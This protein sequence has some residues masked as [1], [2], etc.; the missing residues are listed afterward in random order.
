MNSSNTPG[1]M[2]SKFM[3][4]DIG[5]K[6]FLDRYALKDVGLK[7]L[8]V[9]DLVVAADVEE[10]NT[11][12]LAYVEA[13]NGDQVV[14]RLEDG[15]KHL[16]T[17]DQ[18][19]KPIEHTPAEMH[20]RVSKA[21]V[22]NE[23]GTGRY[24]QQRFEYV[25]KAWKFIPAGR[26]LSAAGSSS[27]LTYYNCYVIKSPKD[28]RQGI[29]ATLSEM[30][31][32]MSR[33]GGVG[34]NISSLRYNSAVIRKV[35]GKSSGS[36]SWAE[37]YSNTTGLISQGGSRRGALLLMLDCWH[38][39]V[40]E[41]I[42]AKEDSD[43]LT[44]ANVTV[45]VY[46]EFMIA[47]KK[48]LDWDLVF[49]DTSYKD[50]DEIW[51]G[52]LTR[53]KEQGLPIKVIK[54]IKAR[55]LWD[56]ISNH[57]WS[58]AEPGLW[59]KDRANKYSNSWY[60]SN[61]ICVNPCGE[62]SLSGDNVCDLGSIN[63]PLFFIP[64]TENS[65]ADIDWEAL[66]FVIWSGVRFLDNVIDANTYFLKQ[67]E[68]Q[69][70]S[71]RRIGLGTMG[72]G[73]LLIRMKL[74]YGSKEAVLF[75]YKLYSFIAHQAYEA[76]V[77]LARER[78]PFLRFDK[79]LFL[80]SKFVQQLDIALQAKIA[81]YGI[82][83]VTI[84]SQAPTGSIATMYGTSTG[85][86]PFYAFEF[87][88]K[89]RL[90]THTIRAGV[91]EEWIENHPGEPLPD[92]FVTAMDLAPQEHVAMLSAV[93]YWTDSSVSKTCNLPADCTPDDVGAV[94][95]LLYDSGCKG[96]TIYRDGSR[97]EQVLMK[98]EKQEEE[99]IV[100]SKVCGLNQDCQTCG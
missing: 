83:N 27:N 64:E 44:N 17:K 20:S 66:S 84:I 85:I 39:D 88:N 100:E 53:W 99:S 75:V 87:E 31:E 89:N 82:R 93:Q 13:I 23:N 38:P 48:D 63:L 34:I 79:E 51:D 98:I 1:F 47:V 60:Y 59:F 50:Y 21:L 57:A 58:S 77:D 55:D 37:L 42:S 90:G 40:L 78:G 68:D 72:L 49:P 71:E 6:I 19:D 8:T 14:V 26:I 30:L 33:G 28:S 70:K 32:I 96:G 94:Y 36:V 91:Y 22:A 9:G 61:L 97:S 81:T 35:N 74:R 18:V 41:F 24:W 56:R 46:D 45:G 80:Q 10:E 2:P 69:Q 16:I 4:S 73:E 29:V 15:G 86:E 62:Q 12:D 92:Y 25:L 43:K 7:T 11:R 54:T 3:L 67:T 76:S 5:M 52:D 95:Q 65:P